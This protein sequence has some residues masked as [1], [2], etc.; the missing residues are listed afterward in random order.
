MTE[1]IQT[2]LDV[3][4]KKAKA[5]ALSAGLWKAL[6]VAVAVCVLWFAIEAG[7]HLY[8]RPAKLDA[9][10]A[11]LETKLA[12]L[13]ASETELTEMLKATLESEKNLAPVAQRIQ[14][15]IQLSTHLPMMALPQKANITQS[16]DSSGGPALSERVVREIKKIGEQLIRIQVV[17]DVQDVAMT[18]AAQS[19][20][21]QQLRMHLLSARLAWLSK[22]PAATRVDLQE[23]EKLL[24]KHYQVQA[25]A[26]VTMQKLLGDLQKEIAQ[27]QQKGQ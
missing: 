20:I 2:S 16:P 4:T 21:H 24:A 6:W 19:L 22:M 11:E 14:E 23:A 12:I 13:E 26:V 27:P 8:Q 1:K 18:P 25:P 5:D 9:R 7:F 17:G 10:V 3:D 15:L